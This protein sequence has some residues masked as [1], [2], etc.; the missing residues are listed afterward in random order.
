MSTISSI[1]TISTVSTF[2]SIRGP[3]CEYLFGKTNEAQAKS[4]DIF[5]RVKLQKPEEK[6]AFV[7]QCLE[8]LMRVN[9]YLL[10]K[11][12][13]FCLIN[14]S[15]FNNQCHLYALRALQ[16][17]KGYSKKTEKERYER[18][19]ENRFIHLA[20]FL[21]YAL[22]SHD[23]LFRRTIDAT[24]KEMGEKPLKPKKQYDTF[25]IDGK[26]ERET[27]AR[28]AFNDV[29]KQY[30]QETLSADKDKSP[31]HR[32][33]S[34]ISYEDL[35][36]E[37]SRGAEEGIFYTYPYAAGIVYMIDTIAREKLVFVMKVKVI[38]KDGAAGVIFQSNGKAEK[39]DFVMIFEAIAT[40]GTLTVPYCRQEA[41]R[42]PTYFYK[43]KDNSKIHKEDESC[44]YCKKTTADLK[45]YIE[46]L[47]TAMKSIDD[48]FYA[49]AADSLIHKQKEF[50]HLFDE[51]ENYPRL[52]KL[53]DDACPNIQKLGLEMDNPVTFSMCHTEVDR[54]SR[55][56]SDEELLLDANPEKFL[57]DR[58]ML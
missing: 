39:D 48:M 38:T 57:K 27:A 58:K 41:K 46:R 15:A 40:D 32:E 36:M 31:L 9:V 50:L 5:P 12:D 22:L 8:L 43:Y 34:L 54:A 13:G 45:P 6:P 11:K 56:F 30:M 42:C 52:S 4:D 35:Q 24:I 1:S 51:N 10:T 20:I 28:F 47:Q 26:R 2:N 3:V 18:T 44:F 7:D 29:F 33:L 49:L 23:T 25:I 53:F 21:N 37:S 14:P 16:I 55:A 19:Q 17:E